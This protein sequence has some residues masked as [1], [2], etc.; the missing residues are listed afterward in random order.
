M[1]LSKLRVKHPF[2]YALLI[3]VI[4][5]LSMS[6]VGGIISGVHM[7]ISPDGS[8][9]PTMPLMLAC[10][11]VV[12]IVLCVVLKKSGRIR[13]LTKTGRGFK[14]GIATGA[15][16]LVLGVFLVVGTI[17]GT[18][19]VGGFTVDFGGG[20]IVCMVAM[21]SI[22]LTEEIEARALIG[23][24]FLEHF[25]TKREGVIRAVVASGLIFGVM[26]IVNALEAPLPDTLCQMTLSITAGMMYGAIYFRSGNLW[27]CVVLHGFNDICSSIQLWLF[28]GGNGNILSSTG[29]FSIDSVVFT[30][31][32]AAID[33]AVA[34]FLL[35]KSK[36]GEVAQTWPEIAEDGG[37]ASDADG[38]VKT[39]W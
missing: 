26:H 14:G 4:F 36:I 35:R 30:L 28:N 7:A 13:L 16:I 20:S 27:S 23:E 34:C 29:D 24:P 38:A 11:I 22:G 37:M 3:F 19:M 12:A 6:I 15:Y 18:Q 10:E 2:L 5:A 9:P 32:L 17:V 8:K 25:G 39:A 1:M 31:V 33:L 21:I